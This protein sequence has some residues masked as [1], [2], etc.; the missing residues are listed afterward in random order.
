MKYRD[1][2]CKSQSKEASLRT[3]LQVVCVCLEK[4][5]HFVPHIL[6]K[7]AGCSSTNNSALY[8]PY[9]SH[10][11]MKEWRWPVKHSSNFY[12]LFY[13]NP[14]CGNWTLQSLTFTRSGFLIPLVA[15]WVTDSISGPGHEVDSPGPS[16]CPDHS[17]AIAALM[18]TGSNSCHSGKP[19]CSSHPY[20]TAARGNVTFALQRETVTA[21]TFYVLDFRSSP[22][23]CLLWQTL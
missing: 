5:P 4:S 23:D 12:K 19:L 17:P 22:G 6:H 1:A 21:Q 10:S 2:F 20:A 18:M 8:G 7:I 14:A 13:S 15:R 3:C 16:P 11:R 9:S